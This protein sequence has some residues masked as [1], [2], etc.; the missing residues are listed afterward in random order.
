M[1][2]DGMI[3]ADREGQALFILHPALEFG[4]SESLVSRARTSAG[5]RRLR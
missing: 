1:L 4:R 5:A 2:Q 3:C